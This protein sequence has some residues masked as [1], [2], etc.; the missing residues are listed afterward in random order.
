MPPDE[1][2]EAFQLMRLRRGG[3]VPWGG[4]HARM[5]AKVMDEQRYEGPLSHLSLIW[6]GC[7]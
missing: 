7:S 3:W 6:D 4:G 1:E 2:S 5:R